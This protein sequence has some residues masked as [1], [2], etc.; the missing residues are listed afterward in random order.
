MRLFPLSPMFSTKSS[1]HVFSTA[2]SAHRRW[3]RIW[4]TTC[5]WKSNFLPSAIMFFTVALSAVLS[6]TH[7]AHFFRR[8]KLSVFYGSSKKKILWS[9]IALY[10]VDVMNYVFLGVK[11]ATYFFL[12]HKD[13]LC[14]VVSGRPRPGMSDT[15]NKNVPPPVNVAS[16]FGIV[17]FVLV[18]AFPASFS[19]FLFNLNAAVLTVSKVHYLKLAPS[20]K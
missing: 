17:S 20:M 14:N 2:Y 13:M 7:F 16:Y 15:R 5:F 11:I 18:K 4:R 9:I 10:P 3:R 19:S 8:V 1:A 6:T 12:H